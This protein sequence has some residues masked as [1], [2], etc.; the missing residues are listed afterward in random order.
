MTD[1]DPTAR[2]RVERA[3]ADLEESL[4]GLASDLVQSPS[5]QGDEGV[6]Q[7]R[8][9]EEMAALGLDVR[10][11]EADDVP[12]IEDHPEYSQTDD[13]YEGRP[14]VIGVRESDGDGR[15]LRFNGHVDV[16][17]AGDESQWSF[18]PYGGE[19]V[20]GDLR[21]RGASDMKGGLAAMLVAVAA[22]D[23][24]G[25]AL[26]GDLV[27]E[28]VIEE[29]AGGYGGTLATVLDDDRLDTD[30]VVIP[31]PTDFDMWIANDGVSYFRVSVEGVSAHAAETD[32]GVNA[33]EKLLP[34]FE[35]LSGL[36]DVRKTTVHDDLFEQWHEHTV[37]L[38][39]GV[40]DGGEW[41]SSVPDEAHL[42]ARISH[43]PEESRE[44]IHHV[45]ESIV[46]LV[47]QDDP[48]L[49]EHPPEV[50]WFGWRGSS[51]KISPDE[52]IV[53]TVQGVVADAFDRES[54]PKGFP[55]GIDSRFFVNYA[56]TPALCFGPGA[57]NIHG[58]DEYVPVAE[59]REM[60]EALALVAMD[61]CGYDLAEDATVAE[62]ESP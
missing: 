29:E 40:M 49:R 4:V 21:G 10:T 56:D 57:Y 12:G 45:V 47:A 24:G 23:R 15:S 41:A 7:A 1:V 17:P 19:V 50:E 44:E 13:D 46:D 62:G 52:A 26:Q 43:A 28:S 18:E 22:L 8:V 6:A 51:A 27:L 31:E 33:I 32:N 11:L 34:V 20:D 54:E 9:R 2:A 58:T 5:V 37:S 3:V 16:V 36:H 25:I 55:G 30:A 42:E 35:A 61:W 53:E 59:L 48:W 14:N 60:T 38:N 39:L